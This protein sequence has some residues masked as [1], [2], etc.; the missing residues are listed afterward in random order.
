MGIIKKIFFFILLPLYLPLSLL[1]NS[2]YD[3]W[4]KQA[5]DNKIVYFILAPLYGP[6]ALFLLWS[7]DWWI[8]L[9]D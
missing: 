2:T 7:F 8:K 5:E 9:L 4:M 6:G 1:I 3:W